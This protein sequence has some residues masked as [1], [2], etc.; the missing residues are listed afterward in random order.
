MRIFP[1]LAVCEQCDGVYRRL[2]LDARELARCPT[3]DAVLAR[4]LDRGIALFLPL[5]E[6]WY[7][8]GAEEV[9]QR[10]C[11]V[12]DPDG[13]LVRCIQPLGLRPAQPTA[14]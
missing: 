11:I 6:R 1:D 13:Y 5:E 12:A 2:A 4:G 14:T 9:G 3:C 8:C 7:R 10:Q